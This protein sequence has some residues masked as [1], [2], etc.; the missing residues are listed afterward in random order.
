MKR[1]YLTLLMA[2]MLLAGCHADAPPP[3]PAVELAPVKLSQVAMQRTADDRLQIPV[4]ALANHIGTPGVFVLEDG[5]ARFR[6]VKA[7]KKNGAWI[8]ISSGLGGDE[9]L[10]AGP[11]DRVYDG[12]PVIPAADQQSGGQQ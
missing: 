1:A 6:M 4:T 7:G 5:L 2:G 12:S 11:F 10:L 8:E 9:V 3:S